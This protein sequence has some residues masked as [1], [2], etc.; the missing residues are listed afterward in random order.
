MYPF[1]PF[2]PFYES[3][4]CVFATLTLV[5]LP[6]PPFLFSFNNLHKIA[7]ARIAR[8]AD[9]KSIS[10]RGSLSAARHQNNRSCLLPL[11]AQACAHPLAF[12]LPDLQNFLRGWVTS[13][14][15][16]VVCCLLGVGEH[17]QGEVPQRR[18]RDI[19]ARTNGRRP[20]WLNACGS[21]WHSVL[22]FRPQLPHGQLFLN[23]QPTWFSF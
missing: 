5:R 21:G 16:G 10:D 15:R 8:T 13:S 9:T 17:W 14:L 20:W 11:T 7:S 2:C 18:H 3:I 6:S 23:I 12:Q 22:R 1:Y 19:E 4:T